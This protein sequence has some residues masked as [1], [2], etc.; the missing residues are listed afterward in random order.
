MA[1]VVEVEENMASSG[2]RPDIR[3]HKG[4]QEAN[5]KDALRKQDH[6]QK[7][8]IDPDYRKI[9]ILI[10]GVFMALIIV[11]LTLRYFAWI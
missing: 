7:R 1:V 11:Y 8:K 3:A 4:I 10:F 6:K 9:G 2:Y 5:V